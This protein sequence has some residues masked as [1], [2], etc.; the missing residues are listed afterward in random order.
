MQE[1]QGNMRK[2]WRRSV[3]VRADLLIGIPSGLRGT[4][5]RCMTVLV[6][7]TAR[8]P[9]RGA[10][11]RGRDLSE[12]ARVSGRQW[13]SVVRSNGELELRSCRE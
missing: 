2:H 3:L 1:D 10:V 13:L 12:A 7:E 8:T 4:C 6:L 9:N 11:L 5:D